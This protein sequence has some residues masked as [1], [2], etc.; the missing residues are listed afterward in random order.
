MLVSGLNCFAGRKREQLTGIP[1]YNTVTVKTVG[2][3]LLLF[4]FLFLPIFFCSCFFLP[5]RYTIGFYGIRCRSGRDFPVPFSILA[6]VVRA[7]YA[8]RDALSSLRH[9]RRMHG[10]ECWAGYCNRDERRS[11]RKG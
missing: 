10:E 7:D 9:T 3:R 2:K 8:L 11:R 5:K 1:V 6:S 4:P